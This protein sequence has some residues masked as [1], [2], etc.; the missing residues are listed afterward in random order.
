MFKS[1]DVI[2]FVSTFVLCLCLGLVSVFYMFGISLAGGGKLLEH[3]PIGRT[4]TC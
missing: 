4:P 1:P 2:A 3:N